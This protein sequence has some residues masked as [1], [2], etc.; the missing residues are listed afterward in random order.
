MT[1]AVH[2][3]AA[4][5][6]GMTRSWSADAQCARASR[7]TFKRP[8]STPLGDATCFGRDTV[9]RVPFTDESMIGASAMNSVL[10]PKTSPAI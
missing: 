10:D 4:M 6:A 5:E 8:R 1:E 9:S 7:R 3:A 2:V